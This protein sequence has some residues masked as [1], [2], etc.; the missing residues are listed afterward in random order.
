MPVSEREWTWVPLAIVI[1]PKAVSPIGETACNFVRVYE[2]SQ[3]GNGFRFANR[4]VVRD[5]RRRVSA[6]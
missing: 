4:C 6:A 5:Q 2:R 3:I 1:L